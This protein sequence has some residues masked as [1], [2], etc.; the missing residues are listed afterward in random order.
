LGLSGMAMAWRE[1]SEQPDARAMNKEEWLG[2]MLD[3]EIAVRADKLHNG[4][5]GEIQRQSG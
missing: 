1:L 3:R 5:L 2:L 4:N